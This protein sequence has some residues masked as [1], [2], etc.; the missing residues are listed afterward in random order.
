MIY[1]MGNLVFNKY[2]QVVGINSLGDSYIIG[3]NTI[4]KLTSVDGDKTVKNTTTLKDYR[5]REDWEEI[6]L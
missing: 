6:V 1:G 5:G 3:G 2:T 4:Q